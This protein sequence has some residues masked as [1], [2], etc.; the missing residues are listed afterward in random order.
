M[1][2]RPTLNCRTEVNP[3]P[4]S[5]PQAKQ[6]RRSGP[7]GLHHI[8]IS[9]ASSSLSLSL[10]RRR[11]NSRF[12]GGRGWRRLRLK[13][14]AGMSGV[15]KP[16]GH[17]HNGR[18]RRRWRNSRLDGGRDWRRRR[19]NATAGL[20][21]VGKPRGLAQNG[22]RRRDSTRRWRE[23]SGATRRR[24]P[25]GNLSLTSCGPM[26]GVSCLSRIFLEGTLAGGAGCHDGPACQPGARAS[27][28]TAALLAG[29]RQGSSRGRARARA[30][31]GEL[32]RNKKLRACAS[33]L[34]LPIASA[35][36][37]SSL[38]L[39]SEEHCSIAQEKKR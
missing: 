27:H 8:T 39:I 26:W 3:L 33:L 14:T 12:D 37:I 5:L 16:R 23:G 13:A 29:L 2:G 10:W 20:S 32:E 21:G 22:R 4:A 17:A 30:Q 7:A 18:R 28:R 19:L 15:G 25:C 6:K 34:A 24:R 1:L 11:R 31:A 36:T 35:T 38:P 9:R